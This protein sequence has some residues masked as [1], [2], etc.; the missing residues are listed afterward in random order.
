SARSGGGPRAAPLVAM[1]TLAVASFAGFTWWAPSLGAAKASYLLPLAG[2]S[3]VFFA[4]A[5]EALPGR[6]RDLGLAASLVAALAAGVVFTSGVV[7]APDLEHA[8][9]EGAVWQRSG[10]LLPGSRIAE[11]GEILDAREAPPR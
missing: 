6:L 8:R 2:A 10:R 3:A 7:F 1:T 5:V 9:A 11:A 4:R